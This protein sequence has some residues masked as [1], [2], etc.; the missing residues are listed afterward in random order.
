MHLSDCVGYFALGGSARISR[1]RKLL[2]LEPNAGDLR[3]RTLLVEPVGLLS[4]FALLLGKVLIQ[5][6][7]VLLLRSCQANRSL[8]IR[9]VLNIAME[10]LLL[11]LL[12]ETGVELMLPLLNGNSSMKKWRS[13]RSA[14]SKRRRRHR[15]SIRD[16]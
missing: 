14:H 16:R 11:S 8:E 10:Y 6:V 2:L 7:K 15:M 9:H 5:S 12:L 4:G 13:L 1:G 3:R